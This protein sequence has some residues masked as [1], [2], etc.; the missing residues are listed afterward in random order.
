MSLVP[1]RK[2]LFRFLYFIYLFGGITLASAQKTDSLAVLTPQESAIQHYHKAT[3][4]NARY[5]NGREYTIQEFRP[6][7]HQFFESLDWDTTSIVYNGY[8]Y[9]GVHAVYDIHR[10]IY[11]IQNHDGLNRIML[12]PE[13]LSGFT[14]HGHRFT[15][16]SKGINP[17]YY[18]VIY[19]GKTKV[20]C[21]R[22]K[23]RTEDLSDRTVQIIYNID[24]RYY[25]L[26]D[27]KYHQVKS[28]KSVLQLLGDKK[29]EVRRFMRGKLY[30]ENREKSIGEMAAYYDQIR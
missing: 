21:K 22:F 4:L 9:D 26:K 10:D 24:D 14:I 27:Q 17:G 5:F 15:R 28:K 16:L 2:S 11:V 6:I 20:Y 19:D 8:S 29:R 30:K 3:F 1:L 25:I 12:S 23:T 7:G 13:D 18:E